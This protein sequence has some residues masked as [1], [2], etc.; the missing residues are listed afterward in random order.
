VVSNRGIPQDSKIG[1]VLSINI[2]KISLSSIDNL[3]DPL[4]SILTYT[5]WHFVSG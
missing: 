2:G 3:T 5:N 4:F 1:F